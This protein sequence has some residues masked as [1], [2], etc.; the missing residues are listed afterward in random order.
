MSTSTPWRLIRTLILSFLLS[1]LLLA[2][3]TLLLYKFRLAE[4]QITAGIYAVYILSCLTGGFLGGKAMKSRRFLWGLIIG[5]LYF[6]VLFAMSA[7][8]N[9]G[10]T[11]EPLQIL[12][13]LAICSVSGMVGGMLS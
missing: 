6:L 10:I 9:R 2:G 5:A 3:L 11:A 1:L 12:T 7:L 13:A 4:S 8:Q